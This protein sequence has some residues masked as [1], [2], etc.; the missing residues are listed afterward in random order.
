AFLL[1]LHHAD[2][3][4]IDQEKVVARSRLQPHFA[5][6]DAA[7]G[8]EISVFEVLHGPAAS[9]ELRVDSDACLLFGSF[10][11]CERLPE[12]RVARSS[13]ELKSG[14]HLSNSA[15]S[16]S[17][18]R[19]GRRNRNVPG[20]EI[21]AAEGGRRSTARRERPARRLRTG[22][23]GPS[24]ICVSVP[25]VASSASFA[26]TVGIAP[27]RTRHTSLESSSR[28]PCLNLRSAARDGFR[29][30]RWSTRRRSSARPPPVSAWR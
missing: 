14:G 29:I 25:H 10:R 2:R 19:L 12:I 4:S 5:K 13:Q 18:G 22:Y 28:C 16:F 8:G 3:P 9:F 17:G 30:R 6:R 1:R 21:P 20:H 24:V 11:H 26:S 27:R 7:T 23:H 15:R